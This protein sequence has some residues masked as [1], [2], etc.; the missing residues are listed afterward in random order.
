MSLK[1]SVYLWNNKTSRHHEKSTAIFS[2][3]FIYKR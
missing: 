1:K 2:N 3:K